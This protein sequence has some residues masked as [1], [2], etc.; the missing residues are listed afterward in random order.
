[1]TKLRK[2]IVQ[3]ATIEFESWL[4]KELIVLVMIILNLFFTILEHSAGAAA[5]NNAR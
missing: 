5:A 1:M 4:S 2:K 3:F